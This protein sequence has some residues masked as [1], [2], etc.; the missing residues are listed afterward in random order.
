MYR[1]TVEL[2]IIA[3][4]CMYY[5]SAWT[6]LNVLD[7]DSGKLGEIVELFSHFTLPLKV[8]KLI[9]VS[10]PPLALLRWVPVC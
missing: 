8:E 4:T 5:F 1:V 2:L 10:L 9:K 6:G 3:H 7:D